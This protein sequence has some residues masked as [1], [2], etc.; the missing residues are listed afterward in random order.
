MDIETRHCGEIRALEDDDGRPIVEGYAAVFDSVTELWPGQF[1]VIRSGAFTRTLKAR[2][3]VRCLLNHD[4]NHVLAR[5]KNGTLVLSED[6]KGLH[7]RAVLDPT[8]S[9]SMSDHAKIRCGRIDQSSFQFS[10]DGEGR[11]G[12]EKFGNWGDD[13]GR[14]REVLRCKLYDVSPVTFPA[15]ED[16]TVAAR[17]FRNAPQPDETQPNLEEGK[18]TDPGPVLHSVPLLRRISELKFRRI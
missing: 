4:P 15:Y 18:H 5:T 9:Q 10:I 7:Y 2:S 12:G 6:N 3:D 11:G 17:A 1:E 13:G 14:L 16:S 8:D